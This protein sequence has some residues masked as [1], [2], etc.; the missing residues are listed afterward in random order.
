MSLPVA[1]SHPFALDI[2]YANVTLPPSTGQLHHKFYILF[3]I[4]CAG[5][6]LRFDMLLI[7][8]P[9][10]IPRSLNHFPSSFL[11]LV[12][13]VLTLTIIYTNS[14]NVPTPKKPIS[15]I[16]IFKK[17]SSGFNV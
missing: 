2:G 8:A 11:I 10:K 12:S 17:L 5:V 6:I 3:F 7:W 16:M 9:R 13:N 14:T 15:H 4:K 1:E